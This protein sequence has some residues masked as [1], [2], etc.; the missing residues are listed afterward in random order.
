MESAFP[1]LTLVVALCILTSSLLAYTAGLAAYR[2]KKE[3][4]DKGTR[5]M[6]RR[7]IV[8]SAIMFCSIL[9]ALFIAEFSVINALPKLPLAWYF[10]SVVFAEV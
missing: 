7:Q 4:S 10:T 1:R 9:A 2:H 8:F 3:A 6:L 5:I